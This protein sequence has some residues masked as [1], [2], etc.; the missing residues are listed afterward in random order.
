MT[1]REGTLVPSLLGKK[2]TIIGLQETV[3]TI[4]LSELVTVSPVGAQSIN[5]LKNKTMSEQ[6]MADIQQEELEIQEMELDCHHW[7]YDINRIP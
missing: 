2:L 1:L 3:G 6:I 5:P 4:K 7:E